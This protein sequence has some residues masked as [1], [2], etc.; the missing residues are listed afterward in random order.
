MLCVILQYI[1]D[2]YTLRPRGGPRIDAWYLLPSSVASAVATIAPIV[3]IPTSTIA[4]TTSIATST[5]ITST[6]LARYFSWPAVFL[7]RKSWPLF[8]LAR[9]SWPAIFL[10]PQILARYFSWPAIF[11]ARYF[12]WPLK[13]FLKRFLESPF[14]CFGKLVGQTKLVVQIRF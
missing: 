4:I 5:R 3:A 12:S 7:A 1:S 10:G 8:F 11:L 13:R 2:S 9:K 6:T 14:K